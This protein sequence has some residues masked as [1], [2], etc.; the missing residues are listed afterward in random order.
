MRR[1]RE[2]KGA[3]E[4][5]APRSSTKSDNGKHKVHPNDTIKAIVKQTRRRRRAEAGQCE[6]DGQASCD[7]SGYA[8][9]GAGQL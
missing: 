3:W 5:G 9:L 8:R 1:C 7:P 2:Q 4:T 6:Q